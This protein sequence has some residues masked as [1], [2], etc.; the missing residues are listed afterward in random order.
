MW[1]KSVPTCRKETDRACRCLIKLTGPGL[2]GYLWASQTEWAY[3]H[4]DGPDPSSGYLSRKQ[5]PSVCFLGKLQLLNI[6]N[7]KKKNKT[8]CDV[9]VCVCVCVAAGGGGSIEEVLLLQIWLNRLQLASWKP[10][11]LF[12]N[13]EKPFPSTENAFDFRRTLLR[14]LWLHRAPC[15]GAH[16]GELSDGTEAYIILALKIVSEMKNTFTF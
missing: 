13:V 1:I 15:E 8:L 3:P 9:C 14:V 4:A 2:W 11:H 5:Q 10:N 12:S 7:R 16:S 6:S